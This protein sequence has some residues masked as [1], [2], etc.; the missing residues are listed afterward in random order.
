MLR[1]VIAMNRLRHIA[2]AVLGAVA[3]GAVAVGCGG[4]D[5]TTTTQAPE[6]KAGPTAAQ[7][8]A[9]AR[10]GVVR[11][12]VTGCG[13][14][15]NGSGF[16]IAPGLVATA[17]HV[18]RGASS[19][20]LTAEGGSSV[21]ATVIGSDEDE[22]LALLRA[23]GTLNA[24]TLSFAGSDPAIGEDVI[25]LGYPLGLP[26]TA[27]RGAITGEDRDMTIEQTNY[28]GLFQ[29]DA[30]VN[31][32]NSGGAI[33]NSAG[34]VVGVVV[35]GGEGYEG[36]GFGVPVARASTVL[37]GWKESPD[38]QPLA[39]C[40]ATQTETYDT[41]PNG[42]QPPDPN[43]A[44]GG[45]AFSSPTGNIHCEEIAD[46]LYC[47]TAND[48]YAVLLPPEGTADSDYT[49]EEAGDGPAV[50]YGESWTSPSGSFTC[51]SASD[52]ITC[53]NQSGNGFFLNRDDFEAF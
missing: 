4:D 21:G 32:G 19:I 13:S 41:P 47:T 29:T 45:S 11:I 37:E 43:V 14:E 46:G 42:V 5:A 49:Y 24:R 28:T 48:G 23:D 25:A 15:G 20:E 52:G 22:D 17:A 53:R 2:I 16:V 9:T 51:E 26:F 30:A 44:S 6:T 18:V 1:G 27:T 39:D 7:A 34:Q 8:I 3:I 40:D 50:P 36:I 33:I 12:D 35:A 31:P 10:K 38:P